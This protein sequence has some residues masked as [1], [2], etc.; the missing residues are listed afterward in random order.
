MKTCGIPDFIILTW[1]NQVS[2]NDENKTFYFNLKYQN[3]CETR[4]AATAR[5][6]SRA[7]NWPFQNSMERKDTHQIWA[8]PGFIQVLTKISGFSGL[9]ISSDSCDSNP[10][11]QN[12][13]FYLKPW[14]LLHFMKTLL[15]MRTILSW[16]TSNKSQGFLKG[17]LLN[18]HSNHDLFT[19]RENR[20]K[21][22][23]I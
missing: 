13:D 4:N 1:P 2:V 9:N 3:N 7:T 16:W 19:L 15:I 17:N 21:A 6:A 20:T 14:M 23:M 22:S 10:E 8:E 18:F 12:I 5:V 11:F